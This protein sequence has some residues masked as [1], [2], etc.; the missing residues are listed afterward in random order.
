[1]MVPVVDV[2]VYEDIMAEIDRWRKSTYFVAAIGFN[3]SRH[4]SESV[5]D[6]RRALELFE[7]YKGVVS[8]VSAGGHVMLYGSRYDDAEILEEDWVI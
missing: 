4:Y 1:M 5:Y 3:G 6:Y 7:M 2:E 8:H